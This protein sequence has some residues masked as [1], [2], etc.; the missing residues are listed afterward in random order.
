LSK[1]ISGYFISNEKTINSKE[2]DTKTIANT[3]KGL[4]VI[5]ER[6]LG[7]INFVE[8]YRKFT[9]LPEPHYKEV[10]LCTLI[11]SNLITASAYPEFSTIKIEK[12]VPKDISFSTDEKLLSQ[13][14]LN[15]LKNALEVLIIENTENPQIGIKL[16]K[17]DSSVKIDISNNGPQIPPELKEQIFVPFFT[18]KENGSGIGLSLSKQIILQMGGDIKL[19]TGRESQTTFSII[20]NSELVPLQK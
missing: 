19:T 7:L 17:N 12:S 8:N 18:T 2:V 5:E 16:I 4:G 13:V 9:K 11:E 6:G 20:L 3:V 10:N 14:I 15:L 1:V